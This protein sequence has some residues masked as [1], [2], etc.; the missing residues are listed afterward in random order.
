MPSEIG[1]DPLKGCHSSTV[2]KDRC[3]IVNIS[4]IKTLGF[5][6]SHLRGRK[7]LTVSPFLELIIPYNAPDCF[8]SHVVRFTPLHHSFY[9]SAL[10]ALT[11]LVSLTTQSDSFPISPP[12]FPSLFPLPSLHA[13]VES[14]NWF[15]WLTWHTSHCLTT[16]C[17]AVWFTDWYC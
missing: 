9:S 15:I 11:F 17:D 3:V 10:T 16:I 12:H 6:Q 1:N 4:C 13:W 2:D 14:Q 8:Y 7:F 5:G